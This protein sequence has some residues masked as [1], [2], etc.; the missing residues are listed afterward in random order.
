[1]LEMIEVEVEYCVACGAALGDEEGNLC[2]KCDA[3]ED[4]ESYWVE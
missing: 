4:E 1:M 2:F 3:A